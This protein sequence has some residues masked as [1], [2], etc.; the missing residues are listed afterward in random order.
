MQDPISLSRMTTDRERVRAA[1]A[2]STAAISAQTHA[3]VD[4]SDGVFTWDY[5]RSRAALGRLYDE[6][7]HAQWRASDLPWETEVDPQRMALHQATVMGG[8]LGGADLSGT[9]FRSWGERE[10][11]ELHIQTQNWVLSQ[12]LHTEQGALLCS[13]KLVESVPWI[14]AKYYAASAVMD[15]A[16]H[17]DVLS[18]YLDTKLGGHYP[19]NAHL[20]ALLDDIVAD[21]RWDMTYLG[22]Q[23]IV[24]GV[25]LAVSDLV[26]RLIDEPLLDELLRRVTADGIRHVAF[27]VVALGEVYGGLSLPE[28]R[29]R[30]EF[31][32][33]LAVRTLDRFLAQEV[34][35]Q[36]GIP[37]E[38][39]VELVVRSPER[40]LFAQMLFSRIVPICRRV[41][42]L[43][44]GDGWLRERFGE[45][46]VL[47]GE[48]DDAGAPQ[49]QTGAPSSAIEGRSSGSTA[50]NMSASRAA[51]RKSPS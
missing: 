30:Q 21:A 2:V 17:V 20:R 51:T 31:A 28:I 42:L 1:M 15:E 40:R 29:E 41:G 35:Q 23:V 48:D 18:R 14:D 50:P 9:A 44:A 45:L 47:G 27:G 25:G 5:T 3:V 12:F 7:L 8:F 33:D 10:W 38:Q 24:E 26:R 11:V 43:D 19:I 16:R 36:M 46:G 37:A 49:A 4:R 6:A 34:W 22:M 32:Y 39:A 13:A